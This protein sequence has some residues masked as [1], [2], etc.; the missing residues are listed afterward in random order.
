MGFER[1]NAIIFALETTT[2][3]PYILYVERKVSDSAIRNE[4]YGFIELFIMRRIVTRATT[5][6]YNQLF[7]DRLILNDILSKQKFLMFLEKQDDKVNFLPTDAQVFD[8]IKSGVLTNKQATGVLYLI[9][10]R[11]RD[12]VRHS[13]QLLG[14]NKYSLEHVMPKKW[15]NHWAR[16]NTQ[17]QID[18][19]N[20][21]LLTLGNLTIITQA[22]N[23]S[24]RDAD[25]KTKKAGRGADKAGLKKY[26]E[27][28][29]TFSDYL[30]RSVWNESVIDERAE[31]L[32]QQ[33]VKVWK[34]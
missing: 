34:V 24:I 27:G 10:S 1:I 15:Q 16:L 17:Q 13:T 30:D 29:D 23:A 19:R 11:I 2:L 28:I 8:A 25:W 5:K 20:R 32:Y 33:A 31:F 4:L 6:N 22:L 18:E 26:A 21:K 3:I 12:R 14:I 9:E 7:T